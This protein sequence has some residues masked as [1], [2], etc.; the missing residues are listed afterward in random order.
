MFALLNPM[1][2][3]PLSRWLYQC[4]SSERADGKNRHAS[5][6]KK[7]PD[8]RWEHLFLYTHTYLL[9]SVE[10]R[11]RADMSKGFHKEPGHQ[12]TVYADPGCHLFFSVF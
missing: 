3:V 6:Q 2:F 10:D 4:I 9:V 5:Y 7:A 12:S 8:E 11:G 1:P